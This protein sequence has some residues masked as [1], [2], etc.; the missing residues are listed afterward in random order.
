M[1]AIVRIGKAGKAFLKK[2]ILP[3]PQVHISYTRRIERVAADRRICAMTFDDGPMDLPASPDLWDGRSL[4]DVLLDTLSEYGAKGTFD[5][6]GDTSENYPDKAGREGSAAWGGEKYDHYPDI[7]KD[8]KGGVVHNDRLVRRMLDEGHQIT[9]HS[10]RHIIFGRKAYVY[11][12]RISLGSMETALSDL[13]R[14]HSLMKERYGYEITM[15]RPPH[16]VDMIG[17]GHTSYDVCDRM[18]YQYLAASFDG[19]GWLPLKGFDDEVEAM[20][21]P[22]KKA[23][24]EDPDFFCGQIIFQKDGYNMA[25]RTPVASG[26]GKQLALLKEYGYE[27]VTVAEL[28]EESPFADVGRDNMQ[29]GRLIQLAKTRGIAYSD[30]T[31]R[32]HQLMT[33]T[34]LAMLLAPKEEVLA[35]AEKP[36]AAALAWCKKMGL[37]GKDVQGGGTVDSLPPVLFSHTSDYTRGSAYAAFKG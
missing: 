23:L 34:E 21:A 16:Y 37:I 32:L 29:L 3:A 30:N 31:L 1:S 18:G 5:V 22:M 15:H 27:V 13:R 9:S 2:N 10:Y 17:D 36:N 4:T 6:V 14:L 35:A 28:M 7:G 8:D 26:L 25:R 20:T 19:A 11:G 33:W 12:R 24:E